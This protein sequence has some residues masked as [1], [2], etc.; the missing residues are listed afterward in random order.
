M[1][2]Q[3]ADQVT[4]SS[5]GKTFMSPGCRVDAR[6]SST[7][8]MAASP[9][10]AGVRSGG[11]LA[12]ARGRRV[13]A[14]L[15][16]LVAGLAVLGSSSAWAADECA[17]AAL[18]AQNDSTRLPDCR[19]Y[20]M[21]SPSYKEGF[22]IEP[23]TYNDDGAV[24]FISLGGFAGQGLGL[25]NSEYVSRR[26]AAG[27]TTVASAPPAARYDTAKTVAVEALSSDFGT[28]LWTSRSLVAPVDDQYFYY[29]RGPDGSM[30]R[31][32]P[33]A[34]PGSGGSAFTDAASADLS[35]ILFAHGATGS[36]S[37]ALAALYEMIGTG[38]AGPARAVSVDNHGQQVPAEACPAPGRSMSDDG[39]VIAFESSCQGSG[40]GVP[41]LW[42]RVAGSATVAVSG[43][44]CTRTP[45][46]PD[47]GCNGVAPVDYAGMAADGSRVFFTTTQQLVDGDTD[48]DNDLYAC[49]IPAGVPAPVGTANPCSALIEISGSATDARVQ[50][51]TA[52]SDDGS[53][54]YFVAQGVLADN[55]GTN[56]A[57]AVEGDSNLYLWTK[58]ATHPTGQTR[59]VTKLA[60][61]GVVNPQTTTD[62]RYLV[63][64]STSPLVTAGPGADTDNAL[65]IYRYDAA[66]ATLMRVSTGVSGSG[67]NAPGLD[68]TINRGAYRSEANVQNSNN[69]RSL[70]A[71]TSDG[72]MVVFQT[73]EAL[74]AEDVDGG[75]DVYAWHDDGRVSLISDGVSGGTQPWI[76]P[77]GRDIF[78]VTKAKLSALDGDVISDIYDARVGGGFDLT[79]PVPCSGDDCQGRPALVPGLRG[80]SSTG[81]GAHAGDEVVPAFSLG[82]VS[83]TQR[84]QLARTGRVTLVI[85]TNTPGTVRVSASVSGLGSVGSAHK[86]ITT[87]GTVRMTLTL[88]KKARDRL[89]KRGKLSV[90]LVVSHSKV[91]LDR[92]ATLR[93]THT[94]T[95]AK[96]KTR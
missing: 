66:T 34:V 80:G 1:S 77:S 57:A 58:D 37:P 2:R 7:L 28:S 10:V 89:V 81:S 51:V 75:P 18:R 42:A 67:G 13:V 49:D 60:A 78:F 17:N 79:R 8:S 64:S 88:A 96:S 82:V 73:D 15:M 14:L 9:T 74:S 90:R 93:L 33:V 36:G 23:R 27:W 56:D 19:A 86:S 87:P 43:S 95:R 54:V 46:D 92:S 85:K 24:A 71:M 62:G 11:V 6:R 53:H 26:S 3:E 91:A 52:V 25:L 69:R 61:G 30:T 70:T 84:K 20:E 5:T 44:E 39:R 72:S 65:D 48:S 12:H 55:L 16:G 45:A 41:G 47:G 35:H 94:K 38:N 83:A 21:V 63:F 29:R 32:G 40:G 68:A 4:V 50:G 22:L 59:F 76:T 31:V